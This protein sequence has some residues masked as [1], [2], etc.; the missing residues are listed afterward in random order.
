MEIISYSC[1][2]NQK[3]I[4]FKWLNRYNK[5]ILYNELMKCIFFKNG[6]NAFSLKMYNI[7]N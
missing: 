4:A 2:T 3:L 7:L 5:I 1:S 6:Y